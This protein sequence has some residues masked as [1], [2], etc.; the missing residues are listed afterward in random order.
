MGLKEEL[1]FKQG[2][3]KKEHE[4]LLNIYYTSNI[5]KKKSIEFF[6]KHNITDVQFNVLELIYYQSG[7]KDGLTQVELSKMLLVN[8]ANITTLIDRME[9]SGLVKREGIPGDRRYNIIKLTT[10]GMNKL[11]K[12]EDS[13]YKEINKIMEI[14]S[15]IEL[16]EL[17]NICEKIRKK[18]RK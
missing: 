13:Y 3:I 15:D 1:N 14:L 4:A 16:N 6:N 11:K 7:D 10:F 18:L 5:I 17:I 9:K 8:R 2:F 12:L